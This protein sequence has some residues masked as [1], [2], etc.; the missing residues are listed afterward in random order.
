MPIIITYRNGQ[1]Q[2]VAG[3]D[4]RY[5][6][7]HGVAG[8]IPVVMLNGHTAYIVKD[9]IRGVEAFPDKEWNE[10][11]EAKKKAEETEA[12]LQKA[13]AEARERQEA[14]AEAQRKDD[15][16]KARLAAIEAKRFIRRVRRF[17]HI[18]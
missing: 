5:F 9:D 10:Q 6:F 13:E 11:V 2:A 15:E 4:L 12:A 1:K 3:E 7:E 8:K 17:L 16:E 14:L 18:G